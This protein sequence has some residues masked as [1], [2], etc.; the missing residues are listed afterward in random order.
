MKKQCGCCKDCLY[1]DSSS[2]IVGDCWRLS[3]NHDWRNKNWARLM[4]FWHMN[5]YVQNEIHCL[6]VE[7]AGNFGC[8]EFRQ[9]EK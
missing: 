3:P 7:T 1:W 9:K 8:V 6:D 5:E 2:P 4:G